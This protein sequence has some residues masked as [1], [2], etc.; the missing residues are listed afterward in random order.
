MSVTV[1]LVWL[2]GKRED[3][4]CES[5][6]VKENVLTLVPRGYGYS[7]REPLRNIPLDRLR[8][9]SERRHS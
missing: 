5:T 7:Y 6:S 1:K 8:E 2:D 3:V 4:D 9:W